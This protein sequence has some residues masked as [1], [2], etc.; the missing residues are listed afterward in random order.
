MEL[1]FIRDDSFDISGNGAPLYCHDDINLFISF[2]ISDVDYHL[3]IAL[4]VLIK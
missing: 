1:I 3:F 4:C 2:C